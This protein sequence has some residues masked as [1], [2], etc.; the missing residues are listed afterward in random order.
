[1][2]LNESFRGPDI[3]KE[4][5]ESLWYFNKELWDEKW[6]LYSNNWEMIAD[7][8]SSYEEKVDNLFDNIWFKELPKIFAKDALENIFNEKV[9]DKI[10]KWR[11]KIP[12]LI[13][14]KKIEL[15]EKYNSD[16]DDANN[17]EEKYNIKHKIAMIPY[18]I[19]KYKE[20]LENQISNFQESIYNSWYVFYLSKEGDIYYRN[21]L[22][23]LKTW[24]LRESPFI[25]FTKAEFKEKLLLAS[26]KHFSSKLA[27]LNK[28]IN[29]KLY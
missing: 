22:Y 26:S 23:D 9:H 27:S 15:L 13:K 11:N 12:N 29:N 17:K 10:L 1:M 16:Y 18:E 24:I 25:K 21:N 3:I 8:N 19:W 2:E 14:N 4:K 28:K 5:N 7:K 20:Y 6:D